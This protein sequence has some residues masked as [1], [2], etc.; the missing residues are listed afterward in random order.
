MML[1]TERLTLR[2]MTWEDRAGIAEILQDPVVMY[3]YEHAFSQDE[4]EEWMARQMERYRTWGFGLWA[5]HEQSTGKLVGQCG[6]M[7]DEA[8]LKVVKLQKGP[9]GAPVETPFAE[10]E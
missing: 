4:V 3:A 9:D 10:E 8:E 7:L 5:V 1:V 6:A 2:E